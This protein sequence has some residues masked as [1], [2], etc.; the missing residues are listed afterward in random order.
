MTD[1]NEIIKYSM[2]FG[3]I[4]NKR[5]NSW[6]LFGGNSKTRNQSTLQSKAIRERKIK[7]KIAKL[8]RKRNRSK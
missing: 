6:G 7:N 3:A 5:L 1:F 2:P 8:S 4:S